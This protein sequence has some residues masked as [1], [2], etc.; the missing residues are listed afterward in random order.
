MKLKLSWL[1]VAITTFVLGVA[2]VSFA[3]VDKKVEERRA[4]AARTNIGKEEIATQLQKPIGEAWKE[5][6][7]LDYCFVDTLYSPEDETPHKCEICAFVNDPVWREFRKRD[8]RE[9]VPF[10]L[11]QLADKQ[12]TNLHVDPC[13]L[14]QKGEFAVYCLQQLLKTNWFELKENY[15]KQYKGVKYPDTHQ[16]LLRRILRNKKSREEMRDLWMKR[17]ES[18]LAAE[19][20]K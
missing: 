18:L 15:E 13:D 2:I 16:D 10:L 20:Q 12:R 9:A 3:F 19:N 5:V 7:S 14:T 4:I 17:F 6:S 8:K 11:R 1:V